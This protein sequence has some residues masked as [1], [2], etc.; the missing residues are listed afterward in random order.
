ATDCITSDELATTAV[1]EIRNAITGG[2]YALDTDANG[3]IRL[4]V[5]TSE[6]EVSLS[7]GGIALNSTEDVYHADIQLTVDDSNSQDE[8]TVIWF[9]NGTRITSG[10]TSPTIQVIKRS[11]GTDLVASTPMTEIG[12]TET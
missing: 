11:D 9:L 4:V 10:I 6:G 7:S 8:Y 1:N 2:A 3:R 12:T 5:G